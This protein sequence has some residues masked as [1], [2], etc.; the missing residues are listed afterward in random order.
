MIPQN[1]QDQLGKI[2]YNEDNS[3][4]FF[5]G[6]MTKFKQVLKDNNI[7]IRP[8]DLK[9]WYESQEIIQ[10]TKPPPITNESIS[11]QI[12]NHKI[13]TSFPFERLY[14]D[15]MY[16][17][18]Y[19]IAII[20]ALD[21]FSRL[22]LAKLYRDTIKDTGI[23]SQK[24]LSALKEFQEVITDDFKYSIFQV[25]TDDGSEFKKAFKS[26]LKEK[27]IPQF[28]SNPLNPHKNANIER[29]NGTLRM[30]IE[31]YKL[32]YGGNITQDIINKLIESYNNTKHSSLLYTPIEICSNIKKAQEQY[33]E[34]LEKQVIEEDLPKDKIIPNDS[35]V[36]YYTRGKDTF[37]KLGKNWSKIIYQIEDYDSQTRTY[38]LKDLPNKFFPYEYLQ[39]INKPLYDRY[40][41]KSTIP[42]RINAQDE[43]RP[44]QNVRITR[45]I[46]DVLNQPIQNQPRQRRAPQRLD[47]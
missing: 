34:N 10:I 18:K 40:N 27:G 47:L 11:K 39:I 17:K 8:K 22:A 19:N 4:K 5:I 30:M 24:A 16:I 32:T 7:N 6:D 38:K 25:Y 2:F 46:R 37:K 13:I 35:Y 15:T 9:E 26:Y 43:D 12:F 42:L 41:Y 23:S 20:V 14:L 1:I 21:Q 31:R 33:N 28:V 44:K 36:R 3:N 45:D 29:F